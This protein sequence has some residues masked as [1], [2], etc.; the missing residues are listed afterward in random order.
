MLGARTIHMVECHSLPPAS[1]ILHPP[2][3]TE[4]LLA[5]HL[6]LNQASEGSNPSGPTD[7]KA[8]VV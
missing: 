2:T 4:V 7:N 6:A 3:G 1:R 8:L 5:A